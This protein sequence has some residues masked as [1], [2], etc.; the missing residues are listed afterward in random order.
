MGGTAIPGAHW[1]ILDLKQPFEPRRAVIDWEVS[2]ATQRTR[3]I[4]VS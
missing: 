3:R 1:I 2:D 4:G